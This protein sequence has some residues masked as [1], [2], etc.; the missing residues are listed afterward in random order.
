ML[1][2]LKTGECSHM[3]VQRTIVDEENGLVIG[4][5]VERLCVIKATKPMSSISASTALKVRHE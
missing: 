2:S 4:G 5:P 3:L 1:P